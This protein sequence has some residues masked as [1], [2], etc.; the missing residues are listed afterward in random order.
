MRALL[1][2]SVS[3]L[4]GAFA[5]QAMAQTP[6]ATGPRTITLGQTVSGTIGP[7]DPK[8]SSDQSS[9]EVFRVQ[10]PAGRRVTAT[11]TSTAFQPVLGLGTNVNDACDGCTINVGET[12]KPAVAARTMTSAGILE[13]RVNTMNAGET[14][15]F[16]LAVNAVVPPPLASQPITYG[17]TKTGALTATDATTGD[18]ST[19][20]D[21]YT[22]RLTAGQQ[23]QIDLSS[24]EFDPKIELMAPGGD[25][26]SDDDDSGPGNSARIRFTAPSAGTY[27]IRA[28]AL[29]DGGM[30]AYTLRAGARPAV[31]PMP[32]PRPLVLGTAT[33][34]AIA[35]NTPTYENDG[36][37][38]VGVRY[39][40]TATA[41]NVY[42]ITATKRDG[43]ELDPKIM[44]GKLV[45][46]VIAD[47]QSDDDGA[48]DLNSALRFRPSTSGVYV[49]EVGRAG[50]TLGA[51]DVKVVQSPPD[52]APGNPIPVSLATDYKGTLADGGPRRSDDNLFNGYSVAL[53]AGQRITVNL[54]KDGE[55]ALDPKVEI[56]KGTPA[57]FEQLF[58]D[59]DGGADLNSRIR[60]VA[61]ADGTY[62]IRATGANVNSE[63]NYVL[64]VEETPPAII[65]LAPTPIAAGQ[66]ISGELAATDPSLNDSTFYDR[67]VLTGQ[68]GETYEIS[69]N[70]EPYDV[71]VGARS[72]LRE[73]D[74][75]QTDDDSG[76]GTNAKLT[77][78]ITT[79]GPQ[80]IRITSLGEEAV[81]KYT[82]SVV[83]K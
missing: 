79:A 60:F 31:V 18:T 11:L 37:E 56:G 58:E 40:F 32:A 12:T 62:I 2:S 61:P 81:G 72:S 77:Y 6:A 57:A 8:L 25:K 34:G 9:Y 22:L 71:I 63:G 15:A 46:G 29:S 75:Y 26:V 64:R 33:P 14:G 39:S 49:V 83:K 42:K 66:A 19:L 7:E 38:T 67:Y 48:G 1:L 17:Q 55:T 59:D 51:Y 21:A 16:T 4:S 73:D 10:V 20:T 3:L 54:R 52:R 53:K 45:N 5:W 35:A 23:V 44:V 69:V 78:T 74:D 76:G 68:V 80:T 30:G 50:E 65:P 28:M 24:S 41:G 82:I 36:E 13:L 70:A 47:P 27:Q 43:S